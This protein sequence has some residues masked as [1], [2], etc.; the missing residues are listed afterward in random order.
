M[1][2]KPTLYIF[3]KKRYPTKNRNQVGSIFHT[4]TYNILIVFSSRDM[5]WVSPSQVTVMTFRRRCS[6]G[7]LVI[8]GL[9]STPVTSQTHRITEKL[10]QLPNK[11]LFPDKE[12]I[13][14]P[15]AAG[16][17]ILILTSMITDL[18]YLDYSANIFLSAHGRV[19]SVPLRFV[20]V[21]Q[22]ACHL[23]VV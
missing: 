11:P 1:C 16:V 3:L 8:V 10:A 4:F 6:N 17:T 9:S 20:C 18:I 22:Y 23:C 7:D 21:I 12:R 2:V 14:K 13:L 5:L 19:F 15:F